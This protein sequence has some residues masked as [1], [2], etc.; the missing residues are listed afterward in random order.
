MINNQEIKWEKLINDRFYL[1]CTLNVPGL[2]LW[3][4]YNRQMQGKDLVATQKY[5]YQ[6]NY[7]KNHHFNYISQLQ[8]QQQNKIP[9]R[10][11]I[12]PECG[13]NIA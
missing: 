12:L 10:E 8:E 4:E 3:K 11:E 6:I 2:Y 5:Q 7:K 9:K 13:D 1:I